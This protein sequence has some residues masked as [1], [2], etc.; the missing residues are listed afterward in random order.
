MRDLIQIP[1]LNPDQRA[2]ARIAGD[3]G[4]DSSIVESAWRLIEV[5]DRL[6]VVRGLHRSIPLHCAYCHA[7]IGVVDSGEAGSSV[8]RLSRLRTKVVEGTVLR[9]KVPCRCRAVHELRLD[10]LTLAYVHAVASGSERMEI[11]RNGR[12][13]AVRSH[14]D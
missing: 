7:P 4:I 6:E 13:V 2:L 3:L 11:H 10:R 8:V 9:L 5:A 1:P 12:L 14:G